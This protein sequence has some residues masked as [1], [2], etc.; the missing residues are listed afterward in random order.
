MLFPE[1]GG[2]S[3]LT[4]CIS[5]C[6]AQRESFIFIKEKLFGWIAEVNLLAAIHFNFLTF[7][8][9]SHFALKN[10]DKNLNFYFER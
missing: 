1:I 10:E 3:A 6:T 5:Y 9:E 8:R 4:P 2:N 7:D